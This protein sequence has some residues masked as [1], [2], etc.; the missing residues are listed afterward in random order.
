MKEFEVLKSTIKRA[1][2]SKNVQTTPLEGIRLKEFEV[3]RVFFGWG[4]RRGGYR[5]VGA[6]SAEW[7]RILTWLFGLFYM[8]HVHVALSCP[9]ICKFIF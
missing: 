8:V 9:S 2:S 4:V 5:A 7:R 6:I 1:S 3:I